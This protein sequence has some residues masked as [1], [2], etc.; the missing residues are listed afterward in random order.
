MLGLQTYSQENELELFAKYQRDIDAYFNHQS[1]I[2]L[3]RMQGLQLE[4]FKAN[5]KV[6]FWQSSPHSQMLLLEGY[7]HHS[8]WSSRECWL[9]PFAV[10]LIAGMGKT[11]QADPHAFYVLGLRELELY[12]QVLSSIIIQLLMQNRQALRNEAQYAELRAEINE[13]H[14]ATEAGDKKHEEQEN[15]DKALR[16][17]EKVALRVLNIFEPTQ[18]VW[19]IIDRVDRCRLRSGFNHQKKLLKTLVHLVEKSKGKVRVL[20]VVNGHD[21]K[22]GEYD[23]ELGQRKE[24]SVILHTVEQVIIN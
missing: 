24:G 6:Q 13:Y 16:L 3:E 23:D 12:P 14:E 17:L 5:K 10:D 8:M 11:G 18:T 19:I 15:K 7:N 9:S 21:W 4:M 20:A 22:V 1:W 2:C